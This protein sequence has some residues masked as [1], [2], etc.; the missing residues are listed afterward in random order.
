[1][2]NLFDDIIYISLIDNFGILK[3]FIDVWN[4]NFNIDSFIL[5]TYSEMN[6]KYID[7]CLYFVWSLTNYRG[8]NPARF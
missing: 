8:V 1:M 7:V 2:N 5:L 4:I 3:K 6:F